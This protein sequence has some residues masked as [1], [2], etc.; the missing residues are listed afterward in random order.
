MRIVVT[1]CCFFLCLLRSTTSFQPLYEP[2]NSR[3]EK[4]ARL[5]T[6]RT[7]LIIAEGPAGTGKT[8]MACQHALRLLAEKKVKRVIV[9]RPTIAADDG[10][11]YLKGGLQE[12]MT[13]WLAPAL[14]V[15]QEFY[16]RD[17]VKTMMDLGILEMAP[18]S[19]MRGRTFKSSFV[20]ADEM[21]NATPSQTKMVL[22]RLG[23]ESR[24]VVTGD[25]AQSD[26]SGNNGLAD[27]I[28]RVE[29]YPPAEMY[30]RGLAVIRFQQEHIER[31]PLLKTL[32]ELYED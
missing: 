3:Q 12:K 8:L 17:K 14:D 26:I 18:I 24:I 13:P 9:T 30:G 27:L 21:Q 25:I 15:F 28:E 1:W 19:F 29:K 7:P 2:R 20:I 4:Y 5:L 16:S 22:T 10:I 23:E 6:E 31:H 32:C 11:G